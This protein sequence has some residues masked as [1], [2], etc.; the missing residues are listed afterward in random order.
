[1]ES[2]KQP[3]KIYKEQVRA[4]GRSLLELRQG[5]RSEQTS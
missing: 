1:M 3:V 2:L 5:R 4:S